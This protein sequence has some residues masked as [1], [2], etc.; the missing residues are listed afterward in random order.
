MR[1]IHGGLD[2]ALR[3]RLIVN[4]GCLCPAIVMGIS[5]VAGRLVDVD[6]AKLWVVVTR[7]IHIILGHWC[8]NH[9]R[10]RMHAAAPH[11]QPQSPYH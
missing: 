7:L 4:H 3:C 8:S 1:I 2:P 10:R 5:G 9:R 11:L 6:R